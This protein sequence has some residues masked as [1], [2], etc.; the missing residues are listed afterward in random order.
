MMVFELLKKDLVLLDHQNRECLH[1]TANTFQVDLARLE[2]YR[3]RMEFDIKVRRRLIKRSVRRCW[4]NPVGNQPAFSTCMR[5]GIGP[6]H[7]F[8]AL[9]FP[10][11]RVPSH[12]AS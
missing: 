9:K 11:Q 5:D 10:S 3:N 4:D 1:G 6:K 12:G 7:T 2:I 8:R